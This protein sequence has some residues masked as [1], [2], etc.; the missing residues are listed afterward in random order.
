M[1]ALPSARPFG[2]YNYDFSLTPQI[3]LALAKRDTVLKPA[4]NRVI[5]YIYTSTI[6]LHYIGSG[7]GA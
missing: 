1:G 4:R 7:N 5:I 6:Y 2:V 3:P